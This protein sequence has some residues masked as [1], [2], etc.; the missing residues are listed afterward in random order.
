ME[1]ENKFI[2][3]YLSRLESEIISSVESNELSSVIYIPLSDAIT[4]IV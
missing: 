2:R 3:I 1:L 4:F